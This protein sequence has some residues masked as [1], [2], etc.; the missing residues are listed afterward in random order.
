V[1]SNSAKSIKFAV[2]RAHKKRSTQWM[3]AFCG[4]FCLPPVFWVCACTPWT[5]IEFFSGAFRSLGSSSLY[6][7][8]WRSFRG[9][10]TLKIRNLKAAEKAQ[11]SK[12]CWSN[13]RPIPFGNRFGDCLFR[14]RSIP[15]SRVFDCYGSVE[16][17]NF[18]S[19][20]LKLFRSVCGIFCLCNYW[21]FGSST[22]FFKHL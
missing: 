13:R 6:R 21:A 7:W 22:V 10:S 2:I 1:L 17:S 5:Q 9:L 8:I 16:W 20:I 3:F 11:I 15:H 4:N 12:F 19:R 14:W 18:F